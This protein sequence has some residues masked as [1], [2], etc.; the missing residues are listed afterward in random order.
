MGTGQLIYYFNSVPYTCA[1]NNA[2]EV[3]FIGYSL[4]PADIAIRV[5]LNHLRQKLARNDIEVTV[6]D[7]YKPV[8]DRWKNFLGDRAK[9]ILKT[10]KDFSLSRP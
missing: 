1:L 9:T 8:L 5:L 7:P 3:T 10:A 4:P 6:V 2:D